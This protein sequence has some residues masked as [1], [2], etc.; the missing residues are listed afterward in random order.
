[1]P[2]A[3]LARRVDRPPPCRSPVLGSRLQKP[4]RRSLPCFEPSLP[5]ALGL[6]LS[7]VALAQA[8]P[9]IPSVVLDHMN[10]LDRA[11]SPPAD[12]RARGVS[13]SRRISRAMAGSTT[14]CRRAITTASAGPG[15]FR[16]GGVGAGGYL[17]RRCA[18]CGAP[19]LFRSAHRLSGA[20]RQAGQGA[21]RPPG[22]GLRGGQ[23][24]PHAVRGATGV[25][26][27]WL[28]RGGCGERPEDARR[29][30]R[31]PAKAPAV[32]RGP[33]VGAAAGS[34]PRPWWC[35]PRRV[36]VFWPNAARPMCRAAP[37]P[38]AG[39]TISA[40]RTGARSPR[41]RRR[42]MPAGRPARRA[43]RGGAAG[44]PAPAP[45]RRALG[46]EAPLARAVGERPLGKLEV[47][48]TGSPAAKTL[49]VNWMEVGAEPPY[50]I[51]GAMRA[52]GVTL[53]EIACEEFGSGEWQRVFSGSAPGRAPFRL[54]LGQRTAPLANSNSYYGATI[55][56]SGRA[57]A[58]PASRRC[59]PTRATCSSP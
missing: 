2:A 41:A 59:A 29:M 28:W 33:A 53:T 8:R 43:G 35:R 47:A 52:R 22:G 55:D 21:D 48:V 57:P 31:P 23:Q 30:R 40:W 27:A 26:R 20:R 34:R 3:R 44:Q 56:L 45:G 10:D 14:C 6:C 49:G 54:E 42:P 18:Q 11:A 50:D 9:P 32:R 25:E 36:R 15:L 46:G 24:R 13:S 51:V 19:R 12:A 38:R 16:Q 5:L 58:P 17:R 4:S 37:T 39:P 7:A 1:M